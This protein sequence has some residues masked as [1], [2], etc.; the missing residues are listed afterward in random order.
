MDALTCARCRLRQLWL[1]AADTVCLGAFCL[2]LVFAGTSAVLVW[3]VAQK[4]PLNEGCHE[5]R[6]NPQK[7]G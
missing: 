7:E 1:R 5:H 3:L 2:L 6:K 4:L